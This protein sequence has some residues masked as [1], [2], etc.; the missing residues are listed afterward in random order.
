MRDKY[1]PLI[2]LALDTDRLGGYYAVGELNYFIS[3]LIVRMWNDSPSYQKANDI[4]GALEC[5]KQEFYRK[6]VAPYEEK[7]IKENGNI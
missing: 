1:D 7:K 2:T 4:I 5:V 3:K 6:Q